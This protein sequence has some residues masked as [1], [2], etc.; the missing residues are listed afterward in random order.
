L[1]QNTLQ[2][3]SIKIRRP[4]GFSESN[5]SVS[6]LI[7][8]GRSISI[9]PL[10]FWNSMVNFVLVVPKQTLNDL[11]VSWLCLSD[12]GKLDAA[13]CNRAC[14]DIFN[15]SLSLRNFGGA[16]DALCTSSKFISWVI[17][18]KI[19]LDALLIESGLLRP[20]NEK[21][22]CKLLAVV[23]P[24]LRR[25]VIDCGK[26]TQFNSEYFTEYLDSDSDCDSNSVGDTKFDDDDDDSSCDWYIADAQDVDPFSRNE[27]SRRS[28][29]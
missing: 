21:V 2:Y 15:N 14:R 11:L 18:R 8:C 7:F 22:R 28:Y 20:K 16:T 23:G 25:A 10:Q 5:Q 29:H 12:V 13:M 19:K 4:S 17:K 27:V 6:L 3:H 24:S 26:D 1:A 9:G